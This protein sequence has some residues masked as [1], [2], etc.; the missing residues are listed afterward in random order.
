MIQSLQATL[1]PLDSPIS[2]L[3][4]HESPDAERFALASVDAIEV[5]PMGSRRALSWRSLFALYSTVALSTGVIGVLLVSVQAHPTFALSAMLCFV[6]AVAGLHVS[7]PTASLAEL[8]ARAKATLHQHAGFTLHH[9]QDLV[10]FG[11]ERLPE[12]ELAHPR[13]T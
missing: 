5:T 6:V 13:C 2:R 12:R 3:M 8:L 4:F 7:A 10:G 9:A 1:R 11:S